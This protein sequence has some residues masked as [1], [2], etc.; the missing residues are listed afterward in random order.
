MMLDEA[1]VVGR[2]PTYSLKQGTLTTNVE[3]TLLSSLGTAND[4]LK[5][6]PGLQIND[7]DVTV[8]GK[9]TPL[10]YINGRQVRDLSELEQLNSKEIAKVELITNPGAEYDAEVKAVLRIKTVKPVGEGIGGSVRTALQKGELWSNNQQVALNYRKQKLDIFG[11]LY[12]DKKRRIEKQ[13][14]LQ[15]H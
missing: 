7:G 5:R 4:V 10:I 1:V 13:E 3:N 8:F 12:Y 15:N 9:G 2:C 6:V 14:D 11:S